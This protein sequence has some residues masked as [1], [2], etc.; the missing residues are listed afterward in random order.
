MGWRASRAVELPAESCDHGCG[1][2]VDGGNAAVLKP[3]AQTSLTAL[4]AVAL[5]R[6][7]GLPPD[8][9]G[10][11]TG[12]GPVVGPAIG[13]RVDYVMFTGSGRTGRVV[14]RQAAERLIGC[15]LELG[16]K[17]PMIV[18]EDANLEKAVDGAVRGCFAAAG[19]I[20]VS[21]E[22]ILVHTSCGTSSSRAS[23]SG[24][25]RS[26]WVRRWTTRRTWD[27]WRRNGRSRRWRITFAT[28]WIKGESV[29]RRRRRPDVGPLFYEATILADV[30]PGMKPMRR[31]RSGRY[32]DV[33]LRVGGRGDRAG[34]CDA[35]R[36]EREHL[37]ADT[38]RGALA[39][40]IR[41]GSVNVNEAYAATWGSVDSPIGGMR[42]SGLRGRHGAEG[43][44]KFTESQTVAVQRVLPIAP[45]RGMDAGRYARWMTRLLMV[46]RATRIAG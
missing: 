11:V 1:A 8:V 17:N 20:C 46:I 27:R 21:I 5:L 16:G 10:V 39:R 26:A 19:Q 45:P 32:I 31:R 41:A 13:A 37:D 12:E 18:L 15:S 28:Q 30:R 14:A 23:W 4:W 44:L 24:R 3:D 35:V 42:E 6:E 40:R 7:A 25:K 33:P 36:V 43:I 9:F 38:D 34:E 22:R 29:D 2:G